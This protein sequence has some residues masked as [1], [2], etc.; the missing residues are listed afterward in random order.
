MIGGEQMK[1]LFY[2]AILFFSLNCKAFAE[3]PTDYMIEYTELNSP[4]IRSIDEYIDNSFLIFEGKKDYVEVDA[5]THSE[6][7][8][9]LDELVNEIEYYI[10]FPDEKLKGGWL[11]DY[12]NIA[13]EKVVFKMKNEMLSP[14]R[15]KISVIE[16]MYIRSGNHYPIEYEMARGAFISIKRLFSEIIAGQYD[17]HRQDEIYQMIYYKYKN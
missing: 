11:L 16:K 9:L 7:K 10:E 6:I 5:E 1:R 3:K 2:V 4:L 13:D 8:E 17:E 12:G 15:E 14:I